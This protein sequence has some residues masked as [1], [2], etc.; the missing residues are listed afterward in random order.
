M[1]CFADSNLGEDGKKSAAQ[2]EALEKGDDLPEK[3]HIK[4]TNDIKKE[5]VVNPN[6]PKAE[7][8]NE[9]DD[10]EEKSSNGNHTP[11]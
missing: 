11:V 2:F 6:E 5:P 1:L 8:V 10:K 3:E 4:E 9:K 7:S